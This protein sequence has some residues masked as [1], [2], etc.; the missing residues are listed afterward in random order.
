MFLDDTW[1]ERAFEALQETFR[2]DGRVRRDMIQFLFD[3]GFWDPGKLGWEAAEKRFAACLNRHKTDTNFKLGEVW[4]LMKRFD[5]HHFALA[6]LEDLGYECRRK[7]TAERQQDLLER[8][9]DALDRYE[10]IA[11]GLRAELGRIATGTVVVQEARPT[12]LERP[13]FSRAD[14]CP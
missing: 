4:A 11:A 14:D 2:V 8:A 5:R 3:E 6:M 10:S 13:T 7:A 9:L 1:F 12:G